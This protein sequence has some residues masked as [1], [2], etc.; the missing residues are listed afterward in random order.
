MCGTRQEP[1]YHLLHHSVV[2]AP[3]AGSGS[4]PNGLMGV[5]TR[6]H[7][8]VV[9]PIVSSHRTLEGLCRWWWKLMCVWGHTWRVWVD[10][11]PAG[12]QNLWGGGSI[13]KGFLSSRKT[14]GKEGSHVSEGWREKAALFV[15]G[16]KLKPL[17]SLTSVDPFPGCGKKR[18]SHVAHGNSAMFSQRG[19]IS[20]P[21]VPFQLLPASR[22][23]SDVHLSDQSG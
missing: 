10:F 2:A 12:S 1:V 22:T 18:V 23:R 4:G 14:W 5:L 15:F 20:E 16:W 7:R 11:L 8:P 17:L 13:V 3:P 19:S 6:A 21:R 9:T